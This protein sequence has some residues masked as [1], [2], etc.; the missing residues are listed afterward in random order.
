[1]REIS[2]TTKIGL[3]IVQAIQHPVTI[4]AFADDNAGNR[5][6]LT[7]KTFQTS[8]AILPFAECI[9]SDSTGWKAWFG[10]ENPTQKIIY[11]RVL[12]PKG[13]EVKITLTP[14]GIGKL[15]YDSTGD[16]TF[17]S[18]IVPSSLDAARQIR[19]ITNKA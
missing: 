13:T 19:E 5:S 1:L 17:E 18:E 6:G 4:D 9:E 15:L 12:L 8:P 14:K 7:S 2:K 10:Y 16:G 3:L 11:T